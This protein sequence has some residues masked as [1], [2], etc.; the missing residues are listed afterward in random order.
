MQ[1]LREHAM[2]MHKNL[3]D[4]TKRISKI[5]SSHL[6]FHS[7]SNLYYDSANF[8]FFNSQVETIIEQHTNTSPHLDSLSKP[9]VIQEDRKS[10]PK[11]PTNDYISRH[12]DDFFACLGCGS[13]THMFKECT[14]T[15]VPTVRSVYWQEH[16][17]HV[18]K[19][20]NYPV[21]HLSKQFL[22]TQLLLLL[23][24][25]YYYTLVILHMVIFHQSQA[26]LERLLLVPSHPSRLFSSTSPMRH[27]LDRSNHL[28]HPG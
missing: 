20:E 4:K 16:W 13:D 17:A 12:L 7:H 1:T 14:N 23:L 24:H 9:L 11:K 10:Y 3:V 28:N 27:G 21:P 2:L 5:I 18:S 25:P 26:Q 19:P 6:H 8:H 15:I 22:V